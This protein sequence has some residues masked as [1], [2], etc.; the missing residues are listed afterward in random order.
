VAEGAVSVTSRAGLKTAP[1][2]MIATW[3]GVLVAHFAVRRLMHEAALR[4]EGDPHRLSCL[5]TRRGDFTA[6]IK[7]AN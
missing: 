3:H 5:P 6:Q 7:S 4:A 1:C 2:D